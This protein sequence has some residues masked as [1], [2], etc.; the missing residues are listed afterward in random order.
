MNLASLLWRILF[1]CLKNK[2]LAT[3][4]EPKPSAHCG[5]VLKTQGESMSIDSLNHAYMCALNILTQE[6]DMSEKGNQSVIE[7]AESA[8]RMLRE[9][10]RDSFVG[11]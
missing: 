6:K 7:Q 4:A 2:T 10:M 3:W 9:K 8:L 1:S 5:I 11:A